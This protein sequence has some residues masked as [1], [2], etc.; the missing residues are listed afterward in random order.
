MNK[1]N[2]LC[3]E[4]GNKQKKV[5]F[6]YRANG[7]AVDV[8]VDCEKEDGLTAEARRRGLIKFFLLGDDGNRLPGFSLEM[9]RP[10]EDRAQCVERLRAEFGSRF[11][12]EGNL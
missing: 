6:R 1:Q 9:P 2:E 3:S 8:R 4:H 11:V 7:A 12:F 10:G 5:Q